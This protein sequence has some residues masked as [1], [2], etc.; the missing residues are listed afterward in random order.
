MLQFKNGTFEFH[1]DFTAR[2]LLFP[3]LFEH[4]V[5]EKERKRE[6]EREKERDIYRQIE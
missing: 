4:N 6:R 3:L 2:I 1:S 5:R